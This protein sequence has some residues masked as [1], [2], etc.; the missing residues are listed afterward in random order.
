MCSFTF[1]PRARF[2]R[3]RVR[4]QIREQHRIMNVH[5]VLSAYNIR[6]FNLSDTSHAYML[7]HHVAA[8][9]HRPT[10]VSDA[11]VIVDAYT[12]LHGH[13]ARSLC[14]QNLI[15]APPLAREVACL[16]AASLSAQE[17][18]AASARLQCVAKARADT[19]IAWLTCANAGEFVQVSVGQE[20]IQACLDVL[21]AQADAMLMEVG[22]RAPP[23][24]PSHSSPLT[25]CAP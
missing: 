14:I 13:L 12:A 25:H 2:V 16:D 24:P 1:V 19:V 4:V 23:L 22:V 15:A 11:L 10:C 7:L 3:G 20:V 17:G 18:T 21:E 8:Q 5:H 6:D 9:V